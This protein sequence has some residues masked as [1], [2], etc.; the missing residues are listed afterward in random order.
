MEPNEYKP[1][2]NGVKSP[3]IPVEPLIDIYLPSNT[4]VTNVLFKY[5]ICAFVCELV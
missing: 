2:Y 4:V 5:T 1:P 3:V